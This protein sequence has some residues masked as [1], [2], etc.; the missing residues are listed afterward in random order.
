MN[1]QVKYV[2]NHKGTNLNL[3]SKDNLFFFNKNM[4]FLIRYHFPKQTAYN[5]FKSSIIPILLFFLSY[6]LTIIKGPFYLGSN[7]DPDY[8]HLFRS[9]LMLHSIPPTYIDHPGT[10]VQLMGAV[11]ILFKQYITNLYQNKSFNKT[12]FNLDHNLAFIW[13]NSHILQ[14]A[15]L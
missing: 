11:I 9:I 2:T 5:I 8:T 13:D 6:S 15:D 10:T 3:Y 4:C 1:G 14:E 7:S 12:S